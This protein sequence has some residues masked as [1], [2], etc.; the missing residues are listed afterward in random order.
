V[1]IGFNH[2]SVNG[3]ALTKARK[4][5]G[6]DYASH[7]PAGYCAAMSEGVYLHNVKGFTNGT[8]NACA[9]S[10]ASES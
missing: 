3:I 4:N 9:G 5:W 2:R 10:I 1:A 6:W 8:E 7:L